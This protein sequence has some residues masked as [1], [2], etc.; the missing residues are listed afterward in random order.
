MAIELLKNLIKE[1]LIHQS[2]I[3]KPGA[4]FVVVKLIDGKWKPLALLDKNKLDI[5]KGGCEDID[6]G[7]RFNTAARECYEECNIVITQQDLHWGQEPFKTSNLDIFLAS[8]EQSPLIKK[9]PISGEFE[10]QGANWVEW[11]ELE[12]GVKNHLKPAIT[13]ARKKIYSV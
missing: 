5:P 4:G 12:S 2:I 10:H 6:S 1:E 8:T 7:S 11:D 13:W 9:N 3:K